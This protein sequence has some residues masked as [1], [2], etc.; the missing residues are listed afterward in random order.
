MS[1]AVFPSFLGESIEVSRAPSFS[2]GIKKAVSGREARASFMMYPLWKLTAKF[3]VLLADCNGTDLLTLEGF[4]LQMRG[5]AES[6]LVLAHSDNAVVDMQFGVGNGAQKDFQL[7]RLRGANGFGMTEPVQNVKTVTDIK[8]AGSLVS[9][10]NYSV[11]SSGMIS[12]VTAPANGAILTWSGQFY[13]RCRFTEDEAQ[14]E[15]FLEGLWKL[16]EIEMIGAP[17]NKV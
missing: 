12:F 4:F 9:S 7:T 8:A 11:G 16:G 13:Y 17:G 10:G 3:D 15:R 5:A 2:T 14:F 1:N 6:F